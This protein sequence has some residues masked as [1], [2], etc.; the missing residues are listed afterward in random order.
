MLLL[1]ENNGQVLMKNKWGKNKM[2]EEKINLLKNMWGNIR[3]RARVY[4]AA[5]ATVL[6]LSMAV[7]SCGTEPPSEECCKEIQCNSLNPAYV[8]PKCGGEGDDCYCRE[9]TCCEQI[10]CTGSDY[11][12]F[13]N[14]WDD[15]QCKCEYNPGSGK[16]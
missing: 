4:S 1:S 8:N 12:C 13:T 3:S 11:D 14:E 15:S 5:G 7:A 2:L 9:K 10:G 6:T 16:P